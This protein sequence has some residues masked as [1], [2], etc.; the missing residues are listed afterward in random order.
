MHAKLDI[1]IERK[2]SDSMNSLLAMVEEIELP[3]EQQIHN[4]MSAELGESELE[5]LPD[6]EEE[7]DEIET[8]PYD[9]EP[10]EPPAGGRQ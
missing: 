4:Q 7:L 1:V 10:A 3:P 2:V 6:P 8:D 9:D 5:Q